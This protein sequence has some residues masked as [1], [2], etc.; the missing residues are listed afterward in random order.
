MIIAAF[1]GN[2]KVRMWLDASDSGVSESANL[3]SGVQQ[4]NSPIRLGADPEGSSDSR[5]YFNGKI[6]TISVQKWRD[7]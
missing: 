6:Q 2:G 5:Y 7:H 3:S 1:D 4:N